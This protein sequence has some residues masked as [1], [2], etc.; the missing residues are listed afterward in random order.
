[1]LLQ[2][3]VDFPFLK[4][5]LNTIPC[6]SQKLVAINVPADA[7]V[8]AIFEPSFIYCLDCYFVS[9]MWH[10]MKVYIR[11]SQ[12]YVRKSPNTVLKCLVFDVFGPLLAIA[13]LI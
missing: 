6:A 4:I 8:F 12:D 1:M 5:S 3:S 11:N 7:T 10:W 13:T 9:N 2:S